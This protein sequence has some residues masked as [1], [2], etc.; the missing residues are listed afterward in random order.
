MRFL[1]MVKHAEEFATSPKELMMPWQYSPKEANSKAGTILEVGVLRPTA[2]SHPRPA[3][4]GQIKVTT[5]HSP[6]Q[7]I[8]R[9]WRSLN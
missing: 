2:Q 6:K 7:E 3:S 5:D 1:M 4:G 9:L 8:R